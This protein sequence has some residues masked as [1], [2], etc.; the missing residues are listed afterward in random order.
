MSEDGRQVPRCSVAKSTSTPSLSTQGVPI[1]DSRT[2]RRGV[3]RHFALWLYF[4]AGTLSLVLGIAGIFLPI[5]P[6]TPFLLLTSYCYIR[7]SPRLHRW[8]L[9]HP[10]F[11]PPL[12]DWER[13]R[14]VRRGVKVAAFVMMA[15]VVVVS[16]LTQRLPPAGLWALTGLFA[17]G[18]FVVWRLPTVKIQLPISNDE[19]P[20]T[21]T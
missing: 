8:L 12:R 15:S 6:T 21:S 14:G 5:L 16:W 2:T 3:F 19:G 18:A 9:H 1:D 4:L 7:S 17:V 10:W 13:H 20:M 11:G